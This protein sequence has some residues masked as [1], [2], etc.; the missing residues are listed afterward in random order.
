MFPRLICTALLVVAFAAGS[1]DAL[2]CDRLARLANYRPA[3][4]RMP[5]VQRTLN[6]QR[7]AAAS[8]APARVVRSVPVAPAP[9][10][11]SMP[12][13]SAAQPAM[14]EAPAGATVTLSHH[15]LGEQP[16][17][18]VLH[19]GG[20]VLRCDVLGWEPTKV[21]FKLPEVLVQQPIAGRLEVSLAGGE[22]AVAYA[23]KLVA[24]PN[25]IVHD[26]NGAASA[27]SSP[28]LVV[29]KYAAQTSGLGLPVPAL[30]LPSLSAGAVN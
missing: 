8:P 26:Q 20:M 19:L 10:A 4:A 9:A 1:P 16:G 17:Q 23:V 12:P 18:V 3:A 25:I 6:N 15:D 22:P 30:S 7:P 21:T 2:G 11:P 24:P 14:L 29:N 5:N 28:R 13:P 27:A